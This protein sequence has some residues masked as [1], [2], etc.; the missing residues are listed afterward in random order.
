M[1]PKFLF[2]SFD[3]RINRQPFWLGVIALLIANG[4]VFA[5]FQAWL[6]WL[7]R[8]ALVYPA[9]AVSV[10]RCHDRGKS[11]WWCLLL[12]IPFVGAVWAVI[13]LGLLTGTDGANTYGPDPLAA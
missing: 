10:K 5:I 13:D 12:L 1:D 9:L 6:A 4:I 8:L 3:G 11:G 7:I 2:L